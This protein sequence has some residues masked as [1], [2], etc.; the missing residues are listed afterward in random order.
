MVLGVD[1]TNG[2]HQHSPERTIENPGTPPP[3]LDDDLIRFDTEVCYCGARRAIE[4]SG[5]PAT[6][7]FQPPPKNTPDN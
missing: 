4:K 6:L 7:W 1:N 3:G 5:Q 2:S